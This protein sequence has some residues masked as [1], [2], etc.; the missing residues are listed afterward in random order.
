MYASTLFAKD[1]EIELATSKPVV[2]GL[3]VIVLPSGKIIIIFLLLLNKK[4]SINKD[5]I[6]VVPP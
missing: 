1:G 3:N 6:R 5:A 4:T 2:P